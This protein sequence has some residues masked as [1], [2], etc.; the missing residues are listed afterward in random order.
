M[1]GTDY[2]TSLKIFSSLSQEKIMILDH[3]YNEDDEVKNR[4]VRWVR[5]QFNRKSF[6]AS[7]LRGILKVEDKIR[8][9][10]DKKMKSNRDCK[11][12]WPDMEKDLADWIRKERQIGI[13]VTT[14]MVVHKALEIH[15][16]VYGHLYSMEGS[17]K[18]FQASKG[19]LHNFCKRNKFSVRVVTL[20]ATGLPCN[21]TGLDPLNGILFKSHQKKYESMGEWVSRESS[22]INN[23]RL[24]VVK[25][26]KQWKFVE[27]NQDQVF[28][29]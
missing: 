5:K 1:I 9:S 3:Y 4:T 23:L 11:P 13:P 16:N 10:T 12:Q 15:R 2:F 27:N 6:S 28:E 8:G 14:W 21:T 18:P 20:N 19:W 26:D 29:M 24:K 7:S 25:E 17:E 22:P